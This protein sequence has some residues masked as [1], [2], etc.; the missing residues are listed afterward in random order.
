MA[1]LMALRMEI[2]NMNGLVGYSNPSSDSPM[3]IQPQTLSERL[4]NK[5][6]SL[7][8]QLK[9]VDET[10]ALLDKNPEIQLVLDHLAKLNFGF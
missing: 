5:K 9:G 1:L 6:A 8:A 3:Q 10:I 4:S 7:E 2:A